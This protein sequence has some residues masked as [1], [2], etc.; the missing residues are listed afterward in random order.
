MAAKF[1]NAKDFDIIIGSTSGS[2]LGTDAAPNTTEP[3][4]KRT[5]TVPR[6]NFPVTIGLVADNTCT[7]EG[8]MYSTSQQRWFRLFSQAI[9]TADAMAFITNIPAGVPITL[10]LTVNGGN[11]KFVGAM[12]I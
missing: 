1:D 9:A 8:W 5:G 6:R 2:A 10:V 11:A 12:F 4:A 3:A 7:V